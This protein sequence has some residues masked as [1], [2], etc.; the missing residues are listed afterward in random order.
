MKIT[1]HWVLPTGR[2]QSAS[3]SFDRNTP[4]G[5]FAVDRAGGCHNGRHALNFSVNAGRLGE[6]ITPANFV[7][8]AFHHHFHD[9]EVA[10]A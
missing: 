9:C 4:T 8:G 2:R 6:T 5:P 3:R 7:P 10:G 1:P